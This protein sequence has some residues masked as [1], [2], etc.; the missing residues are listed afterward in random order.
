MLLC[1]SQVDT[2]VVDTLERKGI[3]LLVIHKAKAL[4]QCVIDHYLNKFNYGAE[5]II[6]SPFLLCAS[7]FYSHRVMDSRM[8]D[9]VKAILKVSV[10]LAFFAPACFPNKS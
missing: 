6:L 1:Y 8:L 2:V 4:S 10:R 9:R 5:T 3:E 7:S